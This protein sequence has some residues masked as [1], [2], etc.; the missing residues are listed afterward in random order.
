MVSKQKYTLAYVFQGMKHLQVQGDRP[1]QFHIRA[2]K[3]S[4]LN[5]KMRTDNV[6][7]QLRYR[8]SPVLQ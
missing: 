3:D 4:A 8:K 7:A 1:Q 6:I 5:K 2:I